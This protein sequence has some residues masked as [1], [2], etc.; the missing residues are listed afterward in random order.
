[1]SIRRGLGHGLSAG[2]YYR[3]P[4]KPCR[5]ARTYKASSVMLHGVEYDRSMILDPRQKHINDVLCI[6][7]ARQEL[8][9][10]EL[11]RFVEGLL[12]RVESLEG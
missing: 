8:E 6:V 4:S 1:M 12:E 9:I 7:V 5:P 2:Y 11:Q 10:L 3:K